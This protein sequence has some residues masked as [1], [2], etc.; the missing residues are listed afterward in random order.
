ML[1]SLVPIWIFMLLPVWI[2]LVGSVLGRAGDRLAALRGASAEPSIHQRLHLRRQHEAH[3]HGRH[4][5]HV[6]A[7]GVAQAA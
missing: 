1:T 4:A 3:A 7:S 2:P 5:A 6:N